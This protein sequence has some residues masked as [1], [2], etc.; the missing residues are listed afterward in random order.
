MR[1]KIS[2]STRNLQLKFNNVKDQRLAKKVCKK[3]SGETTTSNS[4]LNIGTNDGSY[5][6]NSNRGHDRSN[7]NNG[8][9]KSR[10]W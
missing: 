2:N 4:I 6:R 8:R 1:E 9:G 5:E 10:F 7:S 3:N